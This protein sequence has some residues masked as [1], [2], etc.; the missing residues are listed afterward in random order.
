MHVTR[1]RARLGCAL[2]STVAVA[3][4]LAAAGC[5]SL[6]SVEL[7]GCGDGVVEPARGEDCD[8]PGADCGQPGTFAACRLLC[9]TADDCDATAVCGPDGVCRVPSGAF[10][11]GQEVPWTS[12]ALLVGDVDGD[13]APDLVGVSDVAV[14]FRHGEGDGRLAAATTRPS[15]PMR[16]SPVLT[17]LT[18]DGVDDLALSVGLGTH[19]LSNAAIGTFATTLQPSAPIGAAATPMRGATLPVSLGPLETGILTIAARIPQGSDCAAAA[20]CDVLLV[21]DGLGQARSLRRR[22][23]RLVGQQLPWREVT[24]P[25]GHRRFV[26]ATAF[27]DDPTMVGNQSDL[28]LYVVDYDGEQ[29]TLGAEA[30]VPV[31]GQVVAA[32]FGDLGGDGRDDLLVA[33]QPVVGNALRLGYG[34][35]NGDGT[36]A[37]LTEFTVSTSDG[38]GLP[39]PLAW[40]DLDGDSSLEILST[41]G[42]WLFRCGIPGCAAQRV[43]AATSWSDATSADLN[44]DGLLDVIGQRQ[45]GSTVDVR[46]GTGLLGVWNDASFNAPGQVDAI[47]VGDYDGNH[48][49]DIAMVAASDASGAGE[50][51][52]SFGQFL[53][54]PTSPTSMGLVGDVA[55]I[56]PIAYPTPSRLDV[57]SDLFIVFDRG[58]VRSASVMFGSAGRQMIAPLLPATPA[59]PPGATG[60]IYEYT[61]VEALATLESDGDPG[62][63]LLAIASVF[64]RSD[65]TDAN[66]PTERLRLEVRAMEADAVGALTEHVVNDVP[67][68]LGMID[69]SATRWATVPAVGSAPAWVVAGQRGGGILAI[70]IAGCPGSCDPGTPTVLVGAD[71]GMRNVDVTVLDLDGEGELDLVALRVP[72]RP[73]GAGEAWIWR[74]G[75]G[76]PEVIS[77]A[78]GTRPLAAA[79]VRGDRDG[80]A[81]LLFGVLVAGGDG[82]VMETTAGADG[83]Y[84]PPRVATLGDLPATWAGAGTGLARADFNRDGLDDLV[85]A[86][87]DDPAS[88]RSARVYL[89][90]P[91]PGG[92]GLAAGEGK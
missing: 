27:E 7:G 28:A 92:A 45:S 40:V 87:G 9:A 42:P 68:A 29:A 16:G 64:G 2:A 90:R 70:P 88:T 66:A 24:A 23:E 72:D 41:T 4:L 49:P 56:A 15:L 14:E 48:L 54:A 61:E 79:A 51:L 73:D 36:F 74:G 12:S 39:V 31:T 63:E 82:G 46:L 76:D 19:V 85:V 65:R 80:P 53:A 58:A 86:I 62:G 17:D 55:L 83:R 13:A 84:G 67:L 69:F 8:R 91:I 6:P 52:V 81:R 22:L 71:S 25:A 44:G 34:A 21:G 18:G 32:Q 33:I 47:R 10:D 20:G 37:P 5:T 26:V 77:F 59:S 75:V 43:G 57:T 60:P 38:L 78:A 35:G 1:P 11:E 50:L 89:Q 3:S 30:V